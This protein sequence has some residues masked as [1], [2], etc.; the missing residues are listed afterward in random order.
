MAG[1]YAVPNTGDFGEL[2]GRLSDLE[3]RLGELER[4]TGTQKAQAVAALEQAQADLQDQ[5]TALENQQA[6]LSATVT[7]LGQFNNDAERDGQSNFAIS[8]SGALLATEVYTAPNYPTRATVVALGQVTA[9]NTTATLDTLS[10]Q[11]QVTP[12][13]GSPGTSRLQSISIDPG[14]FG[15]LSFAYAADLSLDPL[16]TV[17]VQ[18]FVGSAAASW[19]ADSSN[20]VQ[21]TYMIQVAPVI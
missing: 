15:C 4:P 21:V 9:R 19:P 14:E 20:Q 18:T 3:R 17:T 10:G 12:G 11:V 5:Q 13:V 16:E 6:E 8:S 2:I 1:G 7:L